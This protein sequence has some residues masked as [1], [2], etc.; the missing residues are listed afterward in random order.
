MA[1]LVGLWPDGRYVKFEVDLDSRQTLRDFLTACIIGD[2]VCS[3]SLCQR[4]R[5]TTIWGKVEEQS[6][7]VQCGR[8]R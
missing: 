6:R 4:K 1:S 3:E 2:K 8:T 7:S 5:E